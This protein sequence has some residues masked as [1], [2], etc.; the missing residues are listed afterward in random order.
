MYEVGTIGIHFAIAYALQRNCRYSACGARVCGCSCC[1]FGLYAGPTDAE[2]LDFL[3]S[4]LT[5]TDAGARLL[6][7]AAA[8]ASA[9]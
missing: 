9:Q 7:L 2:R 8:D 5:V 4:K 1:C 3:A 6:K